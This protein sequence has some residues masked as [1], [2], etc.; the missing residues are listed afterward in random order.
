MTEDGDKIDPART[1][2]TIQ[3]SLE[4]AL[5][6]RVWFRPSDDAGE[7]VTVRTSIMRQ[8]VD[9]IEAL[10]EEV[11]LLREK[12]NSPTKVELSEGVVNQREYIRDQILKKG[13]AYD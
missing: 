8:A 1:E 5:E 9:E 12:A 4:K 6:R 7:W 11:R 10:R 13:F 2:L 3:R